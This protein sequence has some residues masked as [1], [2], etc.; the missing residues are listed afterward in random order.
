M[1]QAYFVL[2]S[3]SRDRVV[4]DQR[5]L[6]CPHF[7][8]ITLQ[9]ENKHFTGPEKHFKDL[10]IQLSC[11]LGLRNKNVYSCTIWSKAK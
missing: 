7:N 11:N 5:E 8:N 2:C 9:N 10:F 4:R 3:H 1:H 6:V